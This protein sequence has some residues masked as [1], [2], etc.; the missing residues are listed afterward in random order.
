MLPEFKCGFLSINLS[1]L[2][3]TRERFQIIIALVFPSVTSV[4]YWKF[5]KAVS[6]YWEKQQKSLTMS[7]KINKSKSAAPK[8]VASP[9]KT[10]QKETEPKKQ[11][12]SCQFEVFG[13][14]QG[15][16]FRKVSPYL[17]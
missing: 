4:S 12:F 10:V 5:F 16:F 11:I 13:V 1:R 3:I 17:L 15:V 14:V 8:T 9:P 7:S 6:L 2:S